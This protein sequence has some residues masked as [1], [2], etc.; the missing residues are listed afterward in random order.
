METHRWRQMGRS[1]APKGLK[2]KKDKKKKVMR[3]KDKNGHRKREVG[4]GRDMKKLRKKRENGPKY[5]GT[6]EF[7]LFEDKRIGRN[8]G[9]KHFFYAMGRN[10]REGE[11]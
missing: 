9:E 2:R 11:S 7:D 5:E 3:E 6:G 4:G 1:K 8:N 10:R